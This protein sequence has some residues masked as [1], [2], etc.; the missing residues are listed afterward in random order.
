MGKID[1]KMIEDLVSYK[2]SQLQNEAKDNLIKMVALYEVVIHTSITLANPSKNSA[3][4]FE[5]IDMVA[6]L[7]DKEIEVSELQTKLNRANSQLKQLNDDWQPIDYA[8]ADSGKGCFD[9]K[10]WLLEVVHE[11]GVTI[12]FIPAVWNHVT[13][14]WVAFFT[15]LNKSLIKRARPIPQGWLKEE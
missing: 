7:K 15:P 3:S 4:P 10:E 9:G 1:S 2:Q 11:S 12:C 5:L 13:K 8:Q 14:Q 6:R